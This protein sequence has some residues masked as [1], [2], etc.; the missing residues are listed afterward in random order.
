M[1]GSAAAMLCPP[2][3]KHT[4]TYTRQGNRSFDENLPETPMNAYSV[5]MKYVCSLDWFVSSKY[6][7]VSFVSFDCAA[8]LQNLRLASELH[9]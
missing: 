9:I 7:H 1:L 5:M 2:T 4:L 3:S 6:D 8:L